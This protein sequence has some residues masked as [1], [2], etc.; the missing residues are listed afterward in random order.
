MTRE[1][2]EWQEELWGKKTL[3][4]GWGTA[5]AAG[6]A[7][8]LRGEVRGGGVQEVRWEGRKEGF[9][10]VLECVWAPRK[11]GT[12]EWRWAGAVL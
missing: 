12:R 8:V 9:G 10:L 1:E 6:R 7:E 2:G 11:S 5:D 3:R 4:P